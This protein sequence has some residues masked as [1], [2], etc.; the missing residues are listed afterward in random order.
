[1]FTFVY[2]PKNSNALSL[3]IQKY[4]LACCRDGDDNIPSFA[5]THAIIIIIIITVSPNIYS[6]HFISHS[7]SHRRSF[8]ISIYNAFIVDATFRR[9]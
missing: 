3:H 4:M 6:W 9:K 8:S 5:H 7:Y 2:T 1:M